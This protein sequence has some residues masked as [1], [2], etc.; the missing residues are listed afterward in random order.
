MLKTAQ[1]A[2]YLFRHGNERVAIQQQ[3]PQVAQAP[4]GVLGQ[5]AQAVSLNPEGFQPGCSGGATDGNEFFRFAQLHKEPP[6]QF[7]E[8][9][10]VQLEDPQCVQPVEDPLRQRRERI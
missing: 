8:G 5:C 1:T 6:G 9:V 4:E 7:G 3:N 2:E 10:L